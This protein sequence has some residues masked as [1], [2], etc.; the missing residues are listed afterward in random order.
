MSDSGS[1]VSAPAVAADSADPACDVAHG[2]AEPP[3]STR[4]LVVVF[5]SPVARFL[6]GYAKDAHPAG[7]AGQR[8]AQHRAQLRPVVV[9]H[10]H[11]S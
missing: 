8:V 1:A 7:R 2:R 4:T 11:I 6:L 3:A 9:G 5:I 10:H